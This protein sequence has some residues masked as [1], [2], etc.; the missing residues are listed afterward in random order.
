MKTIKL[1]LT[2]I[3]TALFTACDAT[4]SDSLTLDSGKAIELTVTLNEQNSAESLSTSKTEPQIQ[5]SFNTTDPVPLITKTPAKQAHEPFF[6][7]DENVKKTKNL[8]HKDYNLNQINSKQ[9]DETAYG[10]FVVIQYDDGTV[11]D[12]S[13]DKVNNEYFVKRFTLAS[14]YQPHDPFNKL[15]K[16]IVY[17][18]LDISGADNPEIFFQ[19]LINSPKIT[20]YRGCT[21]QQKQSKYAMVDLTSCEFDN[22]TDLSLY[23]SKS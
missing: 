1:A 2:L 3:V 7:P 16:Y 10:F 20:K 4:S 12:Y 9:F 18:I 23:K 17:K 5:Q 6:L 15:N 13:L 8:F 21:V 22:R 19:E 11:L 14:K